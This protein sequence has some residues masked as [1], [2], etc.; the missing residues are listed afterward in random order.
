V[1]LKDIDTLN[2]DL[3]VELL[4]ECP[5]YNEENFDYFYNSQFSPHIYLKAKNED[6]A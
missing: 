4:Q 1:V 3:Y 5:F 6:L 2:E